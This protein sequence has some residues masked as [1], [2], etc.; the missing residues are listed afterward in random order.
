MLNGLG[1]AWSLNIGAKPNIVKA[2]AALLKASLIVQL[3]VIACFYALLGLFHYRCTVTYKVATRAVVGP[4]ITMYL[5]T[6]LILIRCIYRTVENFAFSISSLSSATDANSISPIL[7]HE[8]FFYVFEASLMLAN[9]VLWN[10]RH[11]RRYLPRDHKVYLAKDGKTEVKGSGWIT[12]T[13]VWVTFVD[14]FGVTA[15]LWDCMHRRGKGAGQGAQPW[16]ENHD[17]EKGITRESR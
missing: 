8:W 11:P 17:E 1:V 16:E 7:R 10:V 4:I 3:V 2:G 15:I 9:V 12:N 6:T 14:P 5:S 13:P